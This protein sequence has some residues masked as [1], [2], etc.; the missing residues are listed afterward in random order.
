M[1]RKV[2]VWGVDP[3]GKVKHWAVDCDHTAL[4][5]FGIRPETVR[6]VGEARHVLSCTGR[7]DNHGRCIFIKRPAT[8]SQAC[9]ELLEGLK[10]SPDIDWLF[11]EEVD[12]IRRLSR[13]HGELSFTDIGGLLFVD[14]PGRPAPMART[15]TRTRTRTRPQPLPADR[16]KNL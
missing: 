1:A 6:M 14:L 4:Q 9:T 15:R 2:T 11:V 10:N 12:Q 3:E 8:I 7:K 5:R 13:R 16:Y